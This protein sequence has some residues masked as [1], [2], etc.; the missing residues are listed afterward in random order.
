MVDL[1][2]SGRRFTWFHSNGVAMS[3]LDCVLLSVGWEEKWV[4]VVS[5]F[6]LD[7]FDNC[8]IMVKY[9]THL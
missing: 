4:R 2:L 3:R 9:L 6:E 5:G 1:S 8:S 7:V